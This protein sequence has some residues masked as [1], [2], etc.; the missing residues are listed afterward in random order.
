MFYQ[1]FHFIPK[2]YVRVRVRTAKIICQISLILAVIY[3]YVH[4]CRILDPTPLRKNEHIVV[5]I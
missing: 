4:V 3:K 1:I 5:C 2:V